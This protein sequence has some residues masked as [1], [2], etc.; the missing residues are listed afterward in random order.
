MNYVSINLAMPPFDDLHVRRAMNYVV[1]QR[2]VARAASVAGGTVVPASH[3]G[4]DSLEDN[5]LLTYDFYGAAPDPVAA[6]REMSRS[7]Y[8]R[9]GDGRCDAPLCWSIPL[10]VDASQPSE[11]AAARVVAEDLQAIGLRVHVDPVGFDRVDRIYSD[12][13]V[14][15]ALF[16]TGWIKDI[17]SASSFF[18]TLFASATP[19]RPNLAMI[20]AS[21]A[22]LRRLGYAPVTIPNVDGL[23]ASC[24]DQ[25]F[26]A[27]THCWASVDQD[28]TENVVPWIPLTTRE[29]A[30]P[31]GPRVRRFTVDASAPAPLPALDQIAISGPEPST[32]TP[33]A[34][35]RNPGVADGVYRAA[36]SPNDLRALVPNATATDVQQT[37]GT[38]TLVVRAGEFW[39]RLEGRAPIE[40]P[41]AVG[42]L[43]GSGDRVTFAFRG[44]SDHW[45]PL[46]MRWAQD[47]KALKLSDVDCRA[48]R[49]PDPFGCGL[50][51]TWFAAHPWAMVAQIPEA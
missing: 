50:A 11:V 30:W 12:P 32:S 20:G 23:L 48:F 24:D 29:S 10:T 35:G 18:S 28:L 1:D 19:D 33:A 16:M 3:I 2:Q 4:L 21:A 14:H 49:P 38:L 34:T 17:Q 46:T 40:E 51:Q 7:A 43:Q 25:T 6:E 36:A 13:S 45:P 26:V 39:L 37:T 5:L 41:Y 22:T 8:D 15:T 44:P 31:V 27:Q 47:G 9:D 42:V